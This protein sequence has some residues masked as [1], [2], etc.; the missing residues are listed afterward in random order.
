MRADGFTR[1]IL[2]GAALVWKWL[3]HRARPARTATVA[4]PERL[5]AAGLLSA[6]LLLLAPADAVR[7]QDEPP[8]VVIPGSTVRSYA[9]YDPSGRRDP[10]V[11][12]FSEGAAGADT[13]PRFESLTLTGIFLGSGANSLAVL[14]DLTHRGHFVRLGQQIGNARLVEILPQAAVFEVREYGASRRIVLRLEREES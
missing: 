5:R 6:V 4:A 13:G 9:Q 14:E 8:Q 2:L 7:A 1:W 11:P 10:F 12:L 3:T